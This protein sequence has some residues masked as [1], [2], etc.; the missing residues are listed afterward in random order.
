M[1]HRRVILAAGI[2]VALAAAAC[3]EDD[4]FSPAVPQYTGGA[5]FQRYVSMGNSLTAGWQSG[6]IND[7]TQKQSYAVLAAAAMGSPFHYPSL[8]NPGCPPPI[9][10]LFTASGTPHRLGGTAAPPCSL[11]SAPLPPYIS[12][13]AVPGATRFDPL[14]RGPALSAHTLPLPI[15]RGRVPV[16]GAG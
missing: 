13:V 12:N 7:S 11:R 1:T 15:L 2:S 16:L 5:M 6:G 9:D 10:T 14:R 3:H 8:N 4:L